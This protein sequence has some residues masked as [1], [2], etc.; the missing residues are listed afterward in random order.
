LKFISDANAAA[1]KL[2]EI[3][4]DFEAAQDGRIYIERV[5]PSFLAA[6][7]VAE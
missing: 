4:N 3:A 6:G 1:R 2:F 7:V 5:S